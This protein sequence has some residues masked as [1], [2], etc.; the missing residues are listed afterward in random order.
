MLKNLKTRTEMMIAMMIAN[1]LFMLD[2][3]NYN[4]QRIINFK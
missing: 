1:D 4:N 3:I 2:N